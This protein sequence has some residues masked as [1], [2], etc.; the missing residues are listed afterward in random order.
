MLFTPRADNHRV[1]G[2]V[3][4]YFRGFGAGRGVGM[5]RRGQLAVVRHRGRGC[6]QPGA[7]VHLGNC[8]DPAACGAAPH[9][10]AVALLRLKD[11]CAP[12]AGK[13]KTLKRPTRGRM[14]CRRGNR[15]CR[16][17]LTDR[18]M[19]G[20]MRARHHA[21]AQ[22]IADGHRPLAARAIEHLGH[23]RILS[24]FTAASRTRIC[25]KHPGRRDDTRWRTPQRRLCDPKTGRLHRRDRPPAGGR[26]QRTAR[27]HSSRAARNGRR[28]NSRS[29]C[30]SAQTAA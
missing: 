22:L 20:A 23:D 18:E 10:A 13:R 5:H 2:S 15:T 28:Y 17:A 24:R 1:P 3:S 29:H 12:R 27:R 7:R 16:A 30:R 19:H 8:K 9:R 14:P 11:R 25:G 6:R 26:D 21:P 4:N